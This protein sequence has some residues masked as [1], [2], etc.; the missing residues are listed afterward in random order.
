[1][2]R[3]VTLVVVCVQIL[4]TTLDHLSFQATDYISI[5]HHMII[6]IIIRKC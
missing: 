3:F 6:A 1:M 5:D 4:K 2:I